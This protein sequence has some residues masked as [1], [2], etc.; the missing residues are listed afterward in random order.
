MSRI[1]LFYLSPNTTGGWVTFTAHLMDALEAAGHTPILRKVGKNTERKTRPFGYGRQYQN[2]SEEDA[3]QLAID[4]KCLIVAAAKKFKEVTSELMDFG[5]YLV[6]HDPTEMKNLPTGLC[7][8]SKQ[9]VVIRAVGLSNPMLPDAQ[10]IPHPYTRA[11]NAYK[12]PKTIHCVSTARID[13]DKHSTILLD[14]NRLLTEPL[15]IKIYGFENRLYTRFKVCPDYPE[16]EQSKCAY[17]RE[18]EA[19]FEIL[20]SATFMA[21]MSVI[22]GDGGGTQY[23][24]LEAWDAGAIPIINAKWMLDTPDE[25]KAGANCLVVHEGIELADLLIHEWNIN[26]KG[27]QDEMIG[28]GY[29]HLKGHA[30]KIIGNQYAE[31]LK[32]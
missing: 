25:M 17:P 5:A 12:R 1:N 13:F 3:Y 8:M 19:A 20:Q 21:D 18:K 28:L 24:F 2:T 29:E 11:M 16:W 10:F 31:F 9:C 23:T 27:Q 30:P 22:K 32:L 14:A 6:V 7:F 26:N 4:E 15:K